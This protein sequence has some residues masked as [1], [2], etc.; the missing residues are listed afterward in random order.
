MAGLGIASIFTDYVEHN[1]ASGDLVQVLPDF[2]FELPRADDATIYL[3]YPDR[4]FLPAR[5]RALIDHIVAET[6]KRGADRAR[7]FAGE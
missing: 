4:T 5:V 2:D 3:Q 6:G 7:S 1:L